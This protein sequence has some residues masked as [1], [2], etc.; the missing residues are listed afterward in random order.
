MRY[1]FRKPRRTTDANGDLWID[2]EFY[3]GKYRLPPMPPRIAM[4]DRTTGAIKVLSDN[5]TNIVLQDPTSSMR[6]IVTY[7]P[8]DGPYS[9]NFRLYLNNGSLAFE[10]V[11][12]TSA[13]E[14][15]NSAR[16]LSRNGYNT[17][18]VEVTANPDGSM[19]QSPVAL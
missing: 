2:G 1:V 3:M 19:V 17:T 18:V 6:D 9:N 16:I 15:Y 5:G 7:G 11:V 4:T 13:Q 10:V 12:I 14:S 8:F